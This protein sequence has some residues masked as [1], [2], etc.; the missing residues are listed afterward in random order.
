MRPSG[1]AV[2]NLELQHTHTDLSALISK[3]LSG[4]QSSL[5][6]PL[7]Q[8]LYPVPGLYLD[9]DQRHEVLVNLVLNAD[10]AI[11]DGHDSVADQT[12]CNPF[13]RQSSAA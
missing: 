12:A 5:R 8:G 4:L 10:Q 2:P 11:D 13:N 6:A 7:M 3:T 9:P 1:P